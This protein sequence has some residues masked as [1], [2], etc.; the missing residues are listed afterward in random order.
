MN[1]CPSTQLYAKS[2]YPKADIR[3][4][5][6]LTARTARPVS[7][8]R[9]GAL[10]GVAARVFGSLCIGLHQGSTSSTVMLPT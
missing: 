8:Y 4:F 6:P 2:K 7:R 10:D 5:G 3:Q 1:D 9:S